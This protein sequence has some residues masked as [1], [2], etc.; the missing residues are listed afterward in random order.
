MFRKIK[1]KLVRLLYGKELDRLNYE[2]AHLY[3]R[4]ENERR[5]VSKIRQ[6]KDEAVK[7]HQRILTTPVPKEQREEVVYR[8]PREVFN[9]IKSMLQPNVVTSSTTDIQAASLVGQQ[10]ALD[11][12]EQEI[13]LE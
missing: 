1:L 7:Q 2:L 13:V 12:I 4:L 11:I 6:E 10:R 3:D 5:L 8:I 9:K